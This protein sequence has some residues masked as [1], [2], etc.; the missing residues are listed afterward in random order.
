MRLIWRHFIK[1][2][3]LFRR[4]SFIFYIPSRLCIRTSCGWWV[5]KKCRYRCSKR[6][7]TPRNSI[8]MHRPIR[9]D[10]RLDIDCY[11]GAPENNLQGSR[12]RCNLCR[13]RRQRNGLGKH[14]DIFLSGEIRSWKGRVRR[15]EA[16]THWPCAHHKGVVLAGQDRFKFARI[17]GD[18]NGIHYG[19]FYAR[20]MGFKRGFRSADT[21]CCPMCFISSPQ[22]WRNSRL[23]WRRC[24]KLFCACFNGRDGLSCAIGFLFERTR[25]LSKH[26]NSEKYP[27]GIRQSIRFVLQRQ[28]ET[29]YLRN[30]L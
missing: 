4:T 18:S 25:I 12:N 3:I 14:Y 21:C 6:H 7:S 17:S 23:A 13:L 27:D 19:S 22:Q 1:F 24:C 10:E 2:A 29:G 28:W 9:H 30:A 26:A 5:H 8:V 16:W 20:M 11:N 15:A